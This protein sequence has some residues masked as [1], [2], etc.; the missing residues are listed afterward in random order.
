MDIQLDEDN[1][2]DMA[3]SGQPSGMDTPPPREASPSLPSMQAFRTSGG[4]GETSPNLLKAGFNAV[5]T[6]LSKT[7]MFDFP[8]TLDQNGPVEL[9]SLD[10]GDSNGDGDVIDSL[11]PRK[12][13]EACSPETKKEEEYLGKPQGLSDETMDSNQ[14]QDGAKDAG[15]GSDAECGEAD[16]VDKPDSGSE[17]EIFDFGEDEPL[18]MMSSEDE[19]YSKPESI[20]GE[21]EKERSAADSSASSEGEDEDEDVE[22]L[23]VLGEDRPASDYDSV[24]SDSESDEEDDDAVVIEDI[25]DCSEDALSE[26]SP[27]VEPGLLDDI[28]ELD[29]PKMEVE[30]S[31]PVPS[32]S[33]EAAEDGP[34]PAKKRKRLRKKKSDGPASKDSGAATQSDSE[35]KPPAKK[36]KK[37]RKRNKD[38]TKK[39]KKEKKKREKKETGEKKKSYERKNIRLVN[40][41]S[42]FFMRLFRDKTLDCYGGLRGWAATEG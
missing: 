11:L 6:D 39:E 5:P 37:P 16:H 10:K 18:M 15:N 32:A 42:L 25:S 27:Q 40:F 4:S 19:D 33:V 29:D 28:S 31:P 8:S 38:G 26:H 1:G 13:D 23:S 17:D 21:K 12:L 41:L 20:V 36:Q 35:E 7:T 30:S 34:P 2:P 9:L 24:S 22:A 3:D 14:L